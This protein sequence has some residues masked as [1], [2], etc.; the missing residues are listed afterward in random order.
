MS[1]LTA[2]VVVMMALSVSVALAEEAAEAPTPAQPTAEHKELA[3]WLGSWSGSGEVKPGPFGP[4]GP[5]EWTEHCA[6]FHG[7]EFHVMC[8]SEGTGPMGPMNGL[9]IIG[10]NP[11]KKVYTHYGVDDT[12]WSG[13]SEGSRSGDTWTF[14]SEEAFEGKTFR[15]RFTMKVK[16]DKQVTFSWD[17]SE[18]GESWMTLMDG[19]NTKQQ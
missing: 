7:V 18:D 11:G 14:S 13:Y 19:I 6:W 9:G 16:S 1:K 2:F 12:G 10:Y 3:V 17:V 5:M 8:R 15:S 4:G